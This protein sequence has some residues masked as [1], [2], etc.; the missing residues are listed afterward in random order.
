MYFFGIEK[1]LPI[2]LCITGCYM[3]LQNRIS[4]DE[5][6]DNSSNIYGR[7]GDISI[8]YSIIN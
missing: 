6:S 2:Y 7:Y 5:N 1:F 4:F 3:R 8:I